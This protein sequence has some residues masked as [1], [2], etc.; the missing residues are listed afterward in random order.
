[1]DEDQTCDIS[2]I[3]NEIIDQLVPLYR[4]KLG[5]GEQGII[6]F[7]AAFF[8]AISKLCGELDIDK[9]NSQRIFSHMWD[10]L[11]ESKRQGLN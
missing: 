2:D 1:M 11:E 7:V 5:E 3:I 8:G 6:E 10:V 9:E 4:K